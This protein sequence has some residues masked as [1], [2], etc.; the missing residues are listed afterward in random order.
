MLREVIESVP[1]NGHKGKTF[2]QLLANVLG[3]DGQPVEV[4]VRDVLRLLGSWAKR[5]GEGSEE[6]VSMIKE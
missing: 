6:L 4:T 5:G 2:A 3:V 1:K